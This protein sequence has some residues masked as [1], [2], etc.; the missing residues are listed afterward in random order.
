MHCTLAESKCKSS[1]VAADLRRGTCSLPQPSHWHH[2]GRDCDAADCASP[3]ADQGQRLNLAA[4]YVRRP[5]IY[6]SHF[7]RQQ[8]HPQEVGGISAAV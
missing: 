5:G 1:V 2:A 7:D 8:G 6:V 4:P 3:W